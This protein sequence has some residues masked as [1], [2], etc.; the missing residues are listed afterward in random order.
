MDSTSEPPP[1]SASGAIWAYRD[2]LAMLARRLCHDA[3]R[4]D[5][6]AHSTLLRALGS[7]RPADEADL[8]RWLHRIAALECLAARRASRD[9]SLDDLVEHAFESSLPDEPLLDD[10]DVAAELDRVRA[11]LAAVERLPERSRTAF[12]LHD[13]AGTPLDELA[14]RLGT[15]V[16]GAKALVHRARAAVRKDLPRDL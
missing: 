15:T 3:D 9:R 10:D 7:N 16:G 4:A 11:V 8:R 6:V 13:G 12:I 2:D 14:T 5:D 1:E